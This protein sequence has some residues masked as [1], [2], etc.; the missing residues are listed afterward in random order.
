MLSKFWQI[1]ILQIMVMAVVFSNG[2]GKSSDKYINELKNYK[3]P[4]DTDVTFS[5]EYNFS[6][7][8]G[9]IW[10]AKVKMALADFKEYTGVHHTYLFIPKRFDSTQPDYRPLPDMKIITVLP[11]STR[12]RIGQLIKDNGI[13]DQLWVTGTLVDVTNSEKIIYLDHLMLANNV[14]ISLGPTS[15]TNWGVNPD[16]LEK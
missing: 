16:M 7:F 15:S 6:S 10:Q 1:I 13:G 2:C 4:P 12:L 9:T 8:S 14:F 5:P 3:K 11:P